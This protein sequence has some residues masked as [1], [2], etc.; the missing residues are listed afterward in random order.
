MQAAL[1]AIG[2]IRPQPVRARGPRLRGRRRF[3][4]GLAGA[5]RSRKTGWMLHPA[6]RLTWINDEVGYGVVATDRIVAGTILW[7]LDPLDRILRADEVEALG[8]DVVTFVDRYSFVTAGGSRVLCWDH[9]RFMNHHCEPT[10]LSPGVHFDL[11]VRDIEPGE[12]ITCDYAALNLREPMR[13][14][15]G[16][17]ECR[18]VVSGYDFEGLA[19]GWDQRLRAAVRY[20]SGVHQPLERWL[21]DLAAL[22]FWSAHPEQLPSSKGH[23]YRR[24]NGEAF[25]QGWALHA[26]ELGSVVLTGS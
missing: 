5:G 11:A 21:P 9:A 18:R 13:C 23:L 14:R 3:A 7:V 19:A 16:H 1:P 25:A 26:E 12:E 17:S 2:R 10:S 4:P 8:G 6:T 20:A 22:A 24:T 15:C